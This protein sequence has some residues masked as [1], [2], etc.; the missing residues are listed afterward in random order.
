[1][2]MQLFSA[3]AVR[4]MRSVISGAAERQRL[5]DIGGLLHDLLQEGEFRRDC[6]LV[7]IPPAWVHHV[8]LGQQNPSPAGRGPG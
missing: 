8:R 6:V 4:P 3:A 7:N 5:R 1:M 2:A